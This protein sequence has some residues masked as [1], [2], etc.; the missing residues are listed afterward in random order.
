MPFFFLITVNDQGFIILTVTKEILFIKPI[1]H[2]PFISLLMSSSMHMIL[3][4]ESEKT[5]KN[6]IMEQRSQVKIKVIIETA[7]CLFSFYLELPFTIIKWPAYCAVR[8]ESPSVI[9]FF[10]HF[11]KFRTV[12]GVLT[13]FRSHLVT[14][15]SFMERDF[16]DRADAY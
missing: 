7:I 9:F 5:R 4:P 10:T 16:Y 13:G 1:C 12:T 14:K 11:L 8:L 2:S 15:E 3:C 6:L